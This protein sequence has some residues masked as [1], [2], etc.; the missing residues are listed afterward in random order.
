M[1]GNAF[2]AHITLLRCVLWRQFGTEST[3]LVVVYV[4]AGPPSKAVD[5]DLTSAVYTRWVGQPFLAVDLGT[6]VPVGRVSINCQDCKCNISLTCSHI[7]EF[8][9]CH[10]WIKHWKETK[11]SKLRQLMS[12][13]P[14]IE[15]N[16]SVHLTLL[17]QFRWQLHLEYLEMD[18]VLYSGVY[19]MPNEFE[20]PLLIIHSIDRSV[21]WIAFCI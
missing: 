3:G 8:Y 12:F 10:T 17:F 11:Y 21:I 18:I 6:S 13:L 16:T 7:T 5:G 9:W 15:K 2:N 14:E 1:H 20:Q 19:G 4:S